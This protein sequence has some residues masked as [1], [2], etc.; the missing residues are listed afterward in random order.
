MYVQMQAIKVE[1][2]KAQENL[3]QECNAKHKKSQE[4]LYKQHNAELVKMH[5]DYINAW[6]I[7]IAASKRNLVE[8]ARKG[9]PRVTSLIS[10]SHLLLQPMC[11]KIVNSFSIFFLLF[12]VE[13]FGLVWWF[14]SS[15]LCFRFL[16]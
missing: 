8:E 11:Y 16:F 7:K 15:Y 3:Y 6:K 14:K 2:E 1:Y 5:E 10:G 13:V 4:E 9:G 12:Y